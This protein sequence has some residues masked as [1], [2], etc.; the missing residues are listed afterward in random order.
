MEEGEGIFK[1]DHLFMRNEN[2][3][4][5]RLAV[6]KDWNTCLF[7]QILVGT[8]AFGTG[9]DSPHV[10]SV[11]HVG[12]ARSVVEYKQESGRAGRDGNPANCVLLYNEA[13]MKKHKDLIRYE[14]PESIR[15]MLQEANLSISTSQKNSDAVQ[16]QD[17]A[18]SYIR[19]LGVSRIE[20]VEYALRRFVSLAELNLHCRMKSLFYE[21]DG[22]VCQRCFTKSSPGRGTPCDVCRSFD[23]NLGNI[24]ESQISRQ[25]RV[26]DLRSTEITNSLKNRPL[27]PSEN[28][29]ER[30]TSVDYVTE[31]DDDLVLAEHGK[32]HFFEDAGMSS[33][34]PNTNNTAK[35]L[36]AHRFEGKRQSGQERSSMR[37][38]AIRRA[39]ADGERS[40]YERVGEHSYAFWSILSKLANLCLVSFAEGLPP[41]PSSGVNSTGDASCFH[42]HRRCFK[43]MRK[44][45]ESVRTRL[46]PLLGNI[47][48]ADRNGNPI[49]LRDPKQTRVVSMNASGSVKPLMNME[50]MSANRD[51]LKLKNP[52]ICFG[53]GLPLLFESISTHP[54]KE[55][56][57]GRCLVRARIKVCLECGAM[58]GPGAGSLTD[59]NFRRTWTTEALPKLLLFSPG[60]VKST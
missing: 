17:A 48:V 11:I 32:S 56:I 6:G 59:L 14:V 41:H 31:W 26:G 2:A 9:I 36:Q 24:D 18:V 54:S 39:S 40:H 10:R 20:G 3:S 52:E 30:N 23:M 29:K 37:L 21:A 47:R 28:G 44:E 13:F 22:V 27:D 60:C 33:A 12:F 50:D 1:W 55:H 16:V 58:T 35:N 7:F 19:T 42:K 34:T 46:C 49:E 25:V 38:P 8:S 57:G 51:Q 45:C 43:C 15:V 53:C 5:S 4:E